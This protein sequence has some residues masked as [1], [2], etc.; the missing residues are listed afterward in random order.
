MEAQLDKYHEDVGAKENTPLRTEKPG[1][2]DWQKASDPKIV[3][4]VKA[5]LGADVAGTGF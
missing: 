4:Q 5:D 3:S 2:Q 1:L